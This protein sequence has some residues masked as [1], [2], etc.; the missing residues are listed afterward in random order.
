MTLQA[1]S[2]LIKSKFATRTV[3]CGIFDLV[4][5]FVFKIAPWI[6]GESNGPRP[7]NL[8]PESQISVKRDEAEVTSVDQGFKKVLHSI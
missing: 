7:L 6:T 5:G 4:S 1:S 3:K 8:V 2:E